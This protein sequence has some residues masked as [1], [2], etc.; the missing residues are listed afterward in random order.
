M[1]LIILPVL[2]YVSSIS[3][4]LVV[5]RIGNLVL[6]FGHKILAESVCPT[7]P[8]NDILETGSSSPVGNRVAQ[9]DSEGPEGDLLIRVHMVL[10][11]ERSPTID[12]GNVRVIRLRRGL[13]KEVGRRDNRT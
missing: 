8:Q 5:D 3:A 7:V 11:N 6:P 13:A 2:V 4:M 10:S 1:L 12:Q 9:N